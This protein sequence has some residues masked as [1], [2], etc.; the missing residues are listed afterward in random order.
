MSFNRNILGENSKED[1]LRL[2]KSNEFKEIFK[3]NNIENVIIFGSL[4][5]DDFNEE[6]DI[7]IAIIGENKISD[8]VDLNLTLELEDFLGR[9]IDLIDIN[10]EEIENIIKIEALNSDMVIIKDRIYEETY[11]YY[12]NLFRENIEFWNRLDRVVLDS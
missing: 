11:N 5:K 3:R 1:I 2:V 4:T 9:S 10:D 6:S 8:T 12:D 7:D